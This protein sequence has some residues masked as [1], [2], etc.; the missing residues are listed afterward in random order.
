MDTEHQKYEE[1]EIKII[2][3]GSR[4]YRATKPITLTCSVKFCH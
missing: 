3:G 2:A 1:N 4:G